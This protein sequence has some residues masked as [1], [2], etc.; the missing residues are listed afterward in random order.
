MLSLVVGRCA[1]GPIAQS[2]TQS[3][4]VCAAKHLPGEPK[5]PGLTVTL[6]TPTAAAVCRAVRPRA[7]AQPRPD[8]IAGHG[9]ACRSEAR[10]RRR[11]NL[12][13]EVHQLSG[14][15]QFN[16][17]SSDVWDPFH[18]AAIHRQAALRLR[19]DGIPGVES[20]KHV[21]GTR[22]SERRVQLEPEG[23]M[24]RFLALRMCGMPPSAWDVQHVPR[25]QDILFRPLHVLGRDLPSRSKQMRQG[26]VFGRRL[27]P[28]ALAPLE[29]NRDHA[30][31]I[32]VRWQS[33]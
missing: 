8:L 19:P 15:H 20:Q 30:V 11:C 13:R 3:T 31:I 29:L 22:P 25:L 6:S 26:C 32:V 2:S 18:A 9:R 33:L 12:D 24:Q 14:A 4:D 5:Q 21:Q 17:A 10:H 1:G 27:K 23:H 16:S 28:P 7:T